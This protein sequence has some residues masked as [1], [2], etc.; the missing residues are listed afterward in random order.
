[1]VIMALSAAVRRRGWPFRVWPALYACLAAIPVVV[2]LVVLL[3]VTNFQD[4]VVY[5]QTWLPLVNPLE[6]GAAFALLGL[7]VFYRV[8][9]RF[10]PVQISVCRPWPLIALLAL[11]FWW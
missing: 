2:A 4:G 8:S 10:F 5:R 3:V 11:S 1:G 6:E 9:Q 7:I